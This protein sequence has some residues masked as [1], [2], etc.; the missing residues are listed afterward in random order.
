[1]HNVR[2]YTFR[3]LPFYFSAY[4]TLNELLAVLY[5]YIIFAVLLKFEMSLNSYFVHNKNNYYYYA[6]SSI[7]DLAS[8]IYL[9]QTEL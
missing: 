8:Q 7:L 2:A 9:T 4:T 6:T 3:F 5:I 1:M